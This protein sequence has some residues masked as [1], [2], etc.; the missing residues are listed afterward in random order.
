M[1]DHADPVVGEESS[2]G[3]NA[4]AAVVHAKVSPKGVLEN[5]SQQEVD[6]LLDRGRAAFTPCSGSAR[7]RS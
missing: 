6:K 5:L 3:G 2:P 7:S 1:N 4:L